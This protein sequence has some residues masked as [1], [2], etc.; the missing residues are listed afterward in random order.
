MRRCRKGD[1]QEKPKSLQAPQFRG[2]KDQKVERKDGKPGENIRQQRAA[3]HRQGSE[4]REAGND[5]GQSPRPGAK[6]QRAQ[7][8][9]NHPNGASGLQDEFGPEMKSLPDMDKQI[10]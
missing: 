6:P 3:E 9:P 10:P 4:K 2:M 7:H 5:D 8:Q 1:E